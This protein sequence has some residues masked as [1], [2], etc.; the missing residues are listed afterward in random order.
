MA[1]GVK[2]FKAG[3][4]LLQKGVKVAVETKILPTGE[5]LCYVVGGA[6]AIDAF[7]FHPNLVS[8]KHS[9]GH[10]NTV[11]DMVAYLLHQD[12]GSLGE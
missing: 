10:N 9:L 3:F 7:D 11:I 2:L 4:H 6:C 1:D 5:S 8:V 12:V